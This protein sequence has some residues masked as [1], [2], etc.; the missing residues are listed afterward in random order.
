MAELYRIT[1]EFYN[2]KTPF[3][4][5]KKGFFGWSEEYGGYDEFVG[6]KITKKYFDTYELAEQYIF[7]KICRGSNKCI[8]S[9]NTYKVIELSFG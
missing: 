8:I 4:I 7:E 2:K 9:G 5:E 6:G 3:C 1:Q